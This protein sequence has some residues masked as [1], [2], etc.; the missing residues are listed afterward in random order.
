MDQ[1]TFFQTR[2]TSWPAIFQL[3]S[4]F[5]DM[6][7]FRGQGNV[8]WELS[9]SLERSMNRFYPNNIDT[10]II[11]IEEK[12][13]LKE[14]KWKYP[15][16]ERSYPEGHDLV[17]WLAIMQHY[18]APTRLLDISNSL[19]IATYFALADNASNDCAIWAI[20]KIA[21]SHRLFDKYSAINGVNTVP[22]EIL[23]AY[24]LKEA[25]DIILTKSLDRKLDPMLYLVKPSRS[26]QRLSRQQGAFLMPSNIQLSFAE[27][28]K[29]YTSNSIPKE[30][31][32]NDL[33]EFTKL[34]KFKQTDISLIKIIIPKTLFLEIGKSLR[35][36][37]IT[38]EILFPGLDGL[39]KSLSYLRYEGLGN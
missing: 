33:V 1:N 17:E 4:S 12:R 13:L 2:L 11:P 18:S 24:A 30:I 10:A 5:I 15:L 21:I 39:C 34:D 28:V 29:S 26:N 36:M 25:N 22:S 6:F 19:F 35:S 20:N 16:Y 14:F 37:N 31:D 8:D 9:S 38:S 3:P 23:D 7:V 32:F 27:H